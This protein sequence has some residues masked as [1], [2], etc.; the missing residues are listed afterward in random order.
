MS[1][2][3]PVGHASATSD[4]CDQCGAPIAGSLGQETAL[5]PG[6]EE[7]DTSTAVRQ[8]PCPAC[9]TA[10][11]GND[12]YCEVCGHDFLAP[13]PT[14]QRWEAV[15]SADRAQFER[16]DMTGVTFPDTYAERHFR[17]DR[18]QLRIGRGR[19]GEQAPEVDLSGSPGDLAV[20]GLHAVL[21]LQDDGSYTVRDLGSTNGTTVNDDPTPVRGDRALPLA[22][23]DRIRVGA[24]TTITIRR[25]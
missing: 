24:W 5:L 22:D 14:A 6:I 18:A 12:R 7:V 13:P 3:C 2:V 17:L 9:G 11:P 16:F 8:E 19:A 23:G 1:L 21:E 10:R 20:S 4:Y 15:V 25:S